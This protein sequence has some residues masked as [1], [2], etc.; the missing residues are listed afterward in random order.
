M[1]MSDHFD[2]SEFTD[3]PKG[4][5]L[6]IVNNPSEK[7]MNNLRALCKFV[8]EP[9]RKHFDKPIK[10][11]SGFRCPELNMAVGGVKTSQHV[12]GQA[13]DIT[14]S[15]VKNSDLWQYIVDKVDFDQVI[16]EK[17][18]KDNGAIG[19][20]H[21]SYDLS[22]LRHDAISFLGHGVYVHGLEFAE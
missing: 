17:L 9:I 21:V 2:L 8:L 22:K 3:S 18:N 5:S 20:V 19:W 15:G 16:A 11:L 1:K 13:A 6:G 14:I 7:E 12:F 10:I 4:K